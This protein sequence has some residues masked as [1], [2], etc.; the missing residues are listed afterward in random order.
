MHALLLNPLHSK[1]SYDFQLN[2]QF[3]LCSLDLA[4]LTCCGL[5]KTLSM[6]FQLASQRGTTSLNASLLARPPTRLAVEEPED[7][8]CCSTWICSMKASMHWLYLWQSWERGYRRYSD[9]DQ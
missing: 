6:V 2:V 9:H 1:I 8:P 5:G 4:P 3:D 7:D